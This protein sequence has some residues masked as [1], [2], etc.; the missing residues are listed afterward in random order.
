MTIPQ[1]H[2]AAGA[3]RVDRLAQRM[4]RATP[5]RFGIVRSPADL[6]QVYRL[7]R[8]VIVEK[9]W[10]LPGEIDPGGDCDRYDD[11][12]VHIAGWDGTALVAGSRLVL[13]ATDRLL[14]TEEAFGMRVEPGRIADIGRV[15]VAAPH[16]GT[17]HRA[18]LGLICMTW[19]AM[20]ARGVSDALTAV[21]GSMTRLYRS[22]GLD[23]LALAPP[24]EYWG[25][26][27]HPALVR[28]A[29][30]PYHKLLQTARR[31]HQQSNGRTHEG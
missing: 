13:P 6:Q 16:R 11:E 10:A 30:S 8:D 1:A 7:R 21:T 14:P 12:A 18:L 9:G 17:T 19:L 29:C 26:I 15:A 28:P 24:R 22:W 25:E 23:V 31:A 3:T 20:R 2:D 5:L 27:R 4:I